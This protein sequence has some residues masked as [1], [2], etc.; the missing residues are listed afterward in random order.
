MEEMISDPENCSGELSDFFKIDRNETKDL[1]NRK[2]QNPASFYWLHQIRRRY[3]PFMQFSKLLPGNI[4]KGILRSLSKT[5]RKEEKLDEQLI[6]DIR[7]K[8]ATG[9]SELNELLGDKIK[10]FGYPME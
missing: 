2:S 10:R 6:K 7:K 3:L 9:N 1:L 4:H 8:F 5:Y